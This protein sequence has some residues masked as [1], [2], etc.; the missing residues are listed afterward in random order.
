MMT[1]KE[2]FDK[3]GG[4]GEE[5]QVAYNDVDYCLK[6]RQMGLLVVYNAFV[7]AYHYESATRGAEDTPEKKKRLK[8]EAALFTSK[9]PEILEKG[10][11]YYNV[12]LTLDNGDCRLRGQ[13]EALPKIEDVQQELEQAEKKAGRKQRRAV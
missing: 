12:N 9:W 10:D 11:P 13:A 3:A 2:I 5:F 6:V 8:R 4:F 7:E 1:P